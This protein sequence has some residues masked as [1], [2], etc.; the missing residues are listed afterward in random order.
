MEQKGSTSTV[1][2]D[3]S[4]TISGADKGF[5]TG[6]DRVERAYIE[7]FLNSPK[8]VLFLARFNRQSALLNQKS[9]RELYTIIQQ[10][11]PWDTLGIGALFRQPKHHATSEVRKT[12]RRLATSWPLLERGLKTHAPTGFVYL[13]VGHSK[14]SPGLWPKLR[15]CGAIK[16]V[17]MIHDLIP[18]DFPQ[19]A[20]SKCTAKFRTQMQA[21]THHADFFVYNST[22]TER[23]MQSWFGKWGRSVHG[24]VVLLGT[25]PLPLTARPSPSTTP[26]FVCLSTIE[27]RKNHKLLLNVWSEF[28]ETLP[29]AE[30]P[31]L[32][33]VGRRGWL[34][35]EVFN[36]L[37]T[38]HFMGK[39]V[40]EHNRMTDEQ[41]GTLMKGSKALLFPSF[42]EGFGYPLVEALQMRVPVICS[43]L[44][45]FHEIAGDAPIFVDTKNQRAWGEEI[46]KIATSD[47]AANDCIEKAPEFPKWNAHFHEI[48]T[49]ITDNI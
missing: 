38:A 4:R 31:H 23:R 47:S 42:A 29:Q 37:D 10:N 45:C 28:H 26:Y 17:A 2:I 20:T 8:S 32:H 33:I 14:L 12:V 11:G 40:F 3:I 24:R 43:N 15:R 41:L 46:R 25:D 27:P 49:I 35:E 9:M 6:I 21:L 19:F 5:L 13:N 30:I 16:I 44:P 48:D 36:T 18:I 34:N 22:D 39:T 1:V 7:H